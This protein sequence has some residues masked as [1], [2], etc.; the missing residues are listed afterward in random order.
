MRTFDYATKSGR[1]AALDYARACV[2]MNL[3]DEA[4]AIVNRFEATRGETPSWV[5]AG[6]PVATEP[7]TAY[8]RVKRFNERFARET[9]QLMDNLKTPDLPAWV[10]GMDPDEAA[11]LCYAKTGTIDP[12]LA[13][14]ATMVVA[15]D[16]T[17]GVLVPESVA[18]RVMGRQLQGA[19]VRPRATVV[20][21]IT[22]QMTV[23]VVTGGSD[24]H[25]SNL[26]GAW[27]SETQTTPD[28]QALTIGASKQ[29][30]NLL[31][32][33]A[34]LTKS[35]LEDAAPQLILATLV[36][37]GG[38][39]LRNSE[40]RAFLIG[41]GAGEPLGILAQQA[42]G[43][44]DNNDVRVTASGAVGALM[45]DAIVACFYALPQIYRDAPGFCWTM[46][47]ATLQTVRTFKSSTGSYLF[48]DDSGL[49]LGK[50]VAESEHMPAIATN[51]Y[52][53]LCGDFAGYQITDRVAL[54]VT[55][56]TTGATT[57]NGVSVM[58][59]DLDL[60]AYFFRERVGGG[61]AEGYRFSAIK[62]G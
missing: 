1:L 28:A 43:V 45:G 61:V 24:V 2:R 51:A 34:H 60:V 3:L 9:Q 41:S 54:D 22:G 44:L 29:P 11:L 6:G 50:P 42:P 36:S 31:R 38:D 40:D 26:R 52:P 47:K 49:L 5:K 12:R 55:R 17:G 4:Q 58:L 13:A 62:V 33:R 32:A 16:T 59:A 56:Y 48:D 10:K 53:V 15:Q 14:K 8:E 19:V 20:P 25:P 23:P 18:T 7:Q 37:Y 35:L 57:V 21:G 27:L 39:A 46:N 30:I